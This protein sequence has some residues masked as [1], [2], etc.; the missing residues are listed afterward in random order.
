[1]KRTETDLSKKPGLRRRE[2]PWKEAWTRNQ[3]PGPRRESNTG[4]NG[5]K[6]EKIRYANLLPL[7]ITLVTNDAQTARKILKVMT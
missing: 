4:L 7:M 3:M 6:R 1:M 2:N 5:A